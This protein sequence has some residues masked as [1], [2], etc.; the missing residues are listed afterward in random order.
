M[1]Y[2][3]R[4][5]ATLSFSNDN[6]DRGAVVESMG[7]WI[8]TVQEFVNQGLDTKFLETLR[9]PEL[10]TEN[11]FYALRP[12][13]EWERYYNTMKADMVCEYET[14]FGWDPLKRVSFRIPFVSYDE[15]TLE[16]TTEYILRYDRDGWVRRYVKGREL[17]QEVTPV[18]TDWDTWEAHKAHTLEQLA[19][20]C[21]PENMEK[22]YGRFRDGEDR[23][24][25]RF[26]ISGFFWLIRDLMGV[27]EHLV[28]YMLEPD[29]IKD[30]NRF[31][32]DVYKQQLDGIL[33]IIKP[34]TLFFEEDYSGGTG[35]MIS[36]ETFEEFISPC[37]REI[38]PFLKERGVGQV[39]LDTDGDFTAMIPTMLECGI[40]GVLPVDVNAGVDIVEVRKAFPTLKFWGGF[41]KLALVKDTEAIEA[42]FRRLMPVIRQGGCIICTDHQTAPHT[43]LENYRYYVR[44]LR[45]VMAENR[46]VHA[47]SALANC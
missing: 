33:K 4:E 1:N 32:L 45:E 26:R 11:L 34:S 20:H 16:D 23:F 5:L 18:V 35:P 19:L 29:L 3:E 28:T 27:E 9:S 40:D 17:V 24:S 7:P 41:D 22:A 6:L 21:T 36:P 25:I 12:Y 8:K 30:I 38:I 44:R 10:P 39:F 43:P 37:Y 2:R 47:Q 14:A 15:K 46:G 13:E 42:E 31:Q